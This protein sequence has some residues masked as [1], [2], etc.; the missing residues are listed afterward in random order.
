MFSALELVPVSSSEKAGW[1]TIVFLGPLSE[2]YGRSII[3]LV[4][5]EY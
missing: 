5:C 1:L 4:S 2:F 3:Y